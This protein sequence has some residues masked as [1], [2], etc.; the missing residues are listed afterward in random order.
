[1][2]RTGRF[3]RDPHHPGLLNEF[4]QNVALLLQGDS[5][6]SEDF[7]EVDHA[8]VVNVSDTNCFA[9]WETIHCWFCIARDSV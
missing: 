4:E 6:E 7:R 5:R 9:Q 2:S 8:A 3:Q 1:M